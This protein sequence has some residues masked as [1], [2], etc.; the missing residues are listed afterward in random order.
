MSIPLNII[1]N[2]PF[3]IQEAFQKLIVLKNQLYHL[4][5]TG[6]MTVNEIMHQSE[7]DKNFIRIQE[8]TGSDKELED[9]IAYQ[10]S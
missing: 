6:H 5:F 10:E 7:I 3:E 2:R 4:M 8:H 1:P 9:F